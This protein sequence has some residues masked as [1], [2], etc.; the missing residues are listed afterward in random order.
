MSDIY[1][2][3]P[4]E[5]LAGLL[6]RFTGIAGMDFSILP[7]DDE[8]P[9]IGAEINENAINIY[10]SD[11]NVESF[12][13]ATLYAHSPAKPDEKLKDAAALL[14][15]L[16]EEKISDRVTIG[17]LEQKSRIDKISSGKPGKKVIKHEGSRSGELVECTILVSTIC[18][19]NS[20][21]TGQKPENIINILSEYFSVMPEVISKNGG[22]VNKFLGDGVMAVFGAP[23]FMPESHINAI[24]SALEMHQA[25]NR[26]KRMWVEKGLPP[27]DHKVGIC[28][29]T[30][31][32]GNVSSP[33]IDV[34]T[35]VGDPI[36]ISVRILSN[37]SPNSTVISHST[38]EK[39][40]PQ[41]RA[42]ALQPI[43][44]PGI[45]GIVRPYEIFAL[46]PLQIFEN[47]LRKFERYE[48]A[49]PVTL[50]K[51][52]SAG[53]SEGTMINLSLGG[54]L[55]TSETDFKSD[56]KVTISFPIEVKDLTVTASG[57]VVYRK[58][59]K[60]PV[61]NVYYHIGIEFDKSVD[62]HLKA[63]GEFLE[64]L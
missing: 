55:F 30:V 13:V 24:A 8:N 23:S 46:K 44:I 12:K 4:K 37:A 6:A 15:K 3:L 59:F 18:D 42:Q 7:T 26:L 14:K 10:E 27:F 47:S 48:V 22:N 20:S 61:G 57:K 5:E 39:V 19:F 21:V 9:I 43:S 45:A 16:I 33:D 17:N 34:Y 58:D 38:F 32:A 40:G 29:G 49:L 25:F 60:D 52:G 11:I 54:V 53:T 64:K 41:V 1:K 63:L 31:I 2:Y 35:L 36:Q 51:T 28:T 50:Q 56:S 62:K